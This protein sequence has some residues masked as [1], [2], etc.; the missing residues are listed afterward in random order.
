MLIR[1]CRTPRAYISATESAA[2]RFAN[3]IVP[4]FFVV[5]FVAIV[6]S[7]I[8]RVASGDAKRFDPSPKP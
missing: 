7:S 2:I 1:A 5:R 3:V 6:V 8:S 4:D